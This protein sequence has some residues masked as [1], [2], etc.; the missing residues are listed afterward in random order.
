M[1]YVLNY[2]KQAGNAKEETRDLW[3]IK[4]VQETASSNYG[5]YINYNVDLN[6]DGDITNDWRIFYDDGK[7][8]FIIAANYLPNTKLP[9]TIHIQLIGYQQVI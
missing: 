1:K 9:Q 7:N 4:L 3:K 8:V 6:D 5:D 2:L